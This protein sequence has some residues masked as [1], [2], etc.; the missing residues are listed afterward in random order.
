MKIRKLVHL[1]QI[2]QTVFFIL[3]VTVLWT[4]TYPLKSVISPEVFF[5]V[6]PFIVFFIS[7]SERILLPGFLYALTVTLLAMWLGRFF[8]GWVCPFGAIHDAVGVF[9]PKKLRPL[10]DRQNGAIR[11]WKYYLLV[12]LFILSVVSF[13]AVWVFDPIVMAARFISMNFIPAFTQVSDSLFVLLIKTFRLYDSPLYDFY[14]AQKA[15]WLGVRTNFFSHSGIIFG[16]FL[17]V[18]GPSLLLARAWCRT[19]CPLG[20]LHALCSRTA[21][22]ERKI[23]DCAGCGICVQKCRMGAIKKDLTYVKSECILCMDCVYDCPKSQTTFSWRKNFKDKTS[24]PPKKNVIT[25]SDFLKVIVMPFL[26]FFASGF[27]SRRLKLS[28]TTGT[29]RSVIR[30]PG[31][32]K[33]H[34]FVDRCVR[35]GNC[36]KVCPTNGLQPDLYESGAQGIWTPKLV[37]EIGCCEYNC[38]LCGNVCPTGAI[39]KLP[40]AVKQKVKLGLAVIDHD[41]CIPWAKGTECLVCEEH[42]PVP[43]KAIKRDYRTAGPL[44]VGRPVV[45]EHLCIGCG[46]CQHVCPVDPV[47]A[48][49]V[50]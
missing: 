1:R 24:L 19:L 49:R 29:V 8:C 32:L 6:D 37:P 21:S 14:R 28:Q 31:A 23:G 41:L 34:E 46:L 2:S 30:P 39:P 38:T 5:W 11:R 27:S 45:K 35:C 48:I 12:I 50:V 13:Q 33:E 40:L 16:F 15:S 20:G 25:R 9:R 44:A 26:V 7:L 42:C 10:S 43:D 36:M 4:T 22:L 18:V 3:F 17:L 47:R